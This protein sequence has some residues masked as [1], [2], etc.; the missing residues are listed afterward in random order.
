VLYRLAEDLG[1]NHGLG[2]VEVDSVRALEVDL[3]IRNRTEQIVAAAR[4][5]EGSYPVLFLHT[6]GAVCDRE[7]RRSSW[8]SGASKP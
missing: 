1:L 8:R 5:A 2:A 3:R 6:D 4:R 7:D